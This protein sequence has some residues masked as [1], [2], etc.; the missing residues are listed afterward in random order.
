MGLLDWF[1]AGENISS[2]FS[3]IFHHTMK[4]P[5]EVAKSYWRA[6]VVHSRIQRLISAQEENELLQLTRT[7]DEGKK[8]AQRLKHHANDYIR[9]LALF[10]ADEGAR[11]FRRTFDSA[12]RSPSDFSWEHT[13]IATLLVIPK[14]PSGARPT[15][16]PDTA[17]RSFS[18]RIEQAKLVTMLGYFFWSEM[19]FAHD[20]YFVLKD[21][22]FYKQENR[23]KLVGKIL[24]D[25]RQDS[26]GSR[27]D[28]LRQSTLRCGWL[29]IRDLEEKE[30]D[31]IIRG[32]H[33]TKDEKEFLM[34]NENLA[35][36]VDEKCRILIACKKGSAFRWEIIKD[37]CQR[38]ENK[39]AFE[40]VE[41]PRPGE[42]FGIAGLPMVGDSLQSILLV[43]RRYRSDVTF[44]FDWDRGCLPFE[45]IL[46]P[47]KAFCGGNLGYS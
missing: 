38:I 29:C 32:P 6:V 17:L 12:R 7:I 36:R 39:K 5:K 16:S 25:L 8:L 3:S 28:E 44:L 40:V 19:E 35:S 26:D 33:L 31:T 21:E 24:D 34:Y 1:K 14:E 46:F 22:V 9:R 37:Y 4:T 30:R 13:P 43:T 42:P 2:A 47:V 41:I 27:I 10:F 11:A 45:T 18:N 20:R 23:E 15:M